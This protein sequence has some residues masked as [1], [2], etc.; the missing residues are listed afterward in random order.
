MYQLKYPN[1]DEI[2]GMRFG[3][4]L[5]NNYHCHFGIYGG[6]TYNGID[7]KDNNLGYEKANCVPCCK[8]CNQ[9]KNDMTMD[10]F[11]NQIININNKLRII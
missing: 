1:H 5:P 10:E 2:T 8:R 11:I 9:M 7:R 4:A 6:Y 3:R